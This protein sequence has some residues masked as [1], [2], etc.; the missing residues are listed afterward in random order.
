MFLKGFERATQLADKSVPAEKDAD[1]AKD[2]AV[3]ASIVEKPKSR[4]KKLILVAVILLLLGGGGAAATFGGFLKKGGDKPAEEAA[5]PALML[6]P[7][8]STTYRTFW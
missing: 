2:D 6:R 3:D 8:F 1:D 5:V 7:V 4:K